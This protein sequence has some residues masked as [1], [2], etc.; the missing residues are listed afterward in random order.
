MANQ[1]KEHNVEKY[2]V[3]SVANCLCA[4]ALESHECL[5]EALYSTLRTW[6]DF[7]SRKFHCRWDWDLLGS[8]K[9]LW[10][11]AIDK[12]HWLISGKTV[13]AIREAILPRKLIS[14]WKPP[15]SHTTFILSLATISTAL[16]H[17]GWSEVKHATGIFK[18][19]ACSSMKTSVELIGAVFQLKVSDWQQ[20]KIHRR[21]MS[22]NY[23][24]TQYFPLFW[25][26]ATTVVISCSSLC[27]RVIRPNYY[28][29]EHITY[30]TQQWADHFYFILAIGAMFL[31][32]F[33][34]LICCSI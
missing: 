11:F 27:T 25:C 1:H 14:K 3:N 6:E 9:Y 33:Y 2:C 30:I 18:P 20:T 10:Q 16:I 17:R 28:T 15:S 29:N 26:L 12:A 24:V 34:H 7:E 13:P 31:L 8:C 5:G 21:S 22:K 4:L 23:F 19:C 32:R